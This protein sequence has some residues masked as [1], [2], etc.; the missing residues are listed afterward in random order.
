MQANS[1]LS[2]GGGPHIAVSLSHA[3]H[4]SIHQQLHRQNVA[5]GGGGSSL[6]VRQE[7][8]HMHPHQMEATPSTAHVATPGIVDPSI[9]GSM[10]HH[11][12]ADN[13]IT[14]ANTAS[15]PNHIRTML[16]NQHL[17]QS[18]VSKS[19]SGG[20][21]ITGTNP[22]LM[23]HQSPIPPPHHRGVH[24]PPL[25]GGVGG[26]DVH[27]HVSL[28]SRGLNSSDHSTSLNSSNSSTAG[29]MLHTQPPISPA[30]PP[31]ENA[32]S[33]HNYGNWSYQPLMVG[34]SESFGLP[35]LPPMQ[36]T[37]PTT[38]PHNFFKATF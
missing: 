14:T 21:V 27:S 17:Q 6:G 3:V 19:G 15:P 2:N 22:I 5:V 4:P 7:Q 10:D 12:S 16:L 36:A 32:P 9:G 11:I 38:Q 28:P 29:G 13:I 33:I 20:G 26:I 30:T 31:L 23:G 18:G 37:T 24:T 35:V 8:H 25:G 34:A 1:S